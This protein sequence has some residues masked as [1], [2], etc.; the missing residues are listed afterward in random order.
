[1]PAH[2][3]IGNLLSVTMFHIAFDKALHNMTPKQAWK[4]RTFE[5]SLNV[6]LGFAEIS[7]K[8]ICH[9]SKRV[10]NCH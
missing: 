2:S 9:Y 5:F 6:F 4:F 10:R 7:D 1:M 3:N 8:I